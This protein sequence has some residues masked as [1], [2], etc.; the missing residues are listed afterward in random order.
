MFV[1]QNGQNLYC[2]DPVTLC[3]II[4]CIYDLRTEVGEILQHT[5]PEPK[6]R[7]ICCICLMTRCS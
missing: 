7:G 2:F 3:I 4:L 1:V 6:A 5:C